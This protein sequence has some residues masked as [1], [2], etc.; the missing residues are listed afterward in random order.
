VAGRRQA[1]QA[2]LELSRFTGGSY[3]HVVSFAVLKQK[4]QNL[5]HTC[6]SSVTLQLGDQ[7]V[8]AFYNLQ[9]KV[10]KTNTPPFDSQNLANQDD[11]ER[12]IIHNDKWPIP[13]T[14]FD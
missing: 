6:T 11:L 12:K 4:M 10:K 2:L 7:K 9:Q 8:N 1:N 14:F 3:N 13:A 5:A